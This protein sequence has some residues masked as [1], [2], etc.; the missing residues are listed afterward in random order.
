[1][2]WSVLHAGGD[3]HLHRPARRLTSRAVARGARRLDARRPGPGTPGRPSTA[4]TSPCRRRA[5]RGRG[6]A[7]TRPASSPAPPPSPCRFGTARPSAGAPTWSRRVHGVLEAEV[8]R[9]LD[10]G[11]ALRA[12][13]TALSRRSR[14]AGRRSPRGRP[15]LKVWSP[16]G[17]NPPA[18][19]PPNAE[20]IGPRRRISSYS[21][22]LSASPS[23]S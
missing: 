3:A 15:S 9:R 5:R 10:V 7:R 6:I 16:R 23:T 8:Q 11:T 20:L 12:A 17:R 2:R 21:L 19:P 22:R 1:M 13:R 14:P 4:R 18:W